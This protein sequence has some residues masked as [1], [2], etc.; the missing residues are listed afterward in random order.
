[1]K[2]IAPIHNLDNIDK[3]LQLD[4]FIISNSLFSSRLTLSLSVDEINDVINKLHNLKK[5][6][7]L[8]LNMMYIDSDI[9]RLKEFLSKIN[10]EKLTG[11]IASDYG[12]VQLLIDLGLNQKIVWN[13]E[14]LSTNAFDFNILSDYNALGSFVSKE[15]TIENILEI[16]KNKKYNLFII[17]HGHLNMFYSKR[18]LISNFDKKYNLNINPNQ[19][20]YKLIENKRDNQYF[21][22]LQDSHGTYV[23]RSKVKNSFIYLNKLKEVVDYFII[24]SIF[25]D[26]RYTKEVL[27]LYQ[28][29]Y[30]EL[31]VKS[32]KEKY[33]EKWDNGFYDVQTVYIKE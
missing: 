25:K 6:V 3:L 14:T 11:I 20:T 32:L 1:M 19:K 13:G 24:D 10:T 21:P 26:D 9:D 4:G 27:D 29:G 31:R 33:D 17:G 22:I 2:Y 30:D 7:F 18:L 16:G 23:F 28:N 15:I 8:S 5:E 12:V